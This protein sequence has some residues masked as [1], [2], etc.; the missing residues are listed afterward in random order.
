MNQRDLTPAYIPRRRQGG[1]SKPVL[2]PGSIRLLVGKARGLG[3]RL[4]VPKSITTS[5][6]IFG[7]LNSGTW[8]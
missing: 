4:L 2:R 6:A 8:L 3:S 5:N 7:H 1:A